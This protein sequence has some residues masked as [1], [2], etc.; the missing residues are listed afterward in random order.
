MGTGFD[1]SRKLD[2]RWRAME[3]SG[4]GGRGGGEA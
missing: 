4:I 3:S 2:S 1:G